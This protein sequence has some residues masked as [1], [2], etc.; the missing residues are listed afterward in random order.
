MKSITK[1]HRRAL[2]LKA[3]LYSSRFTREGREIRPFH[4]RV[5]SR[6]I[7][8]MEE[9]GKTVSPM[10]RQEMEDSARN[11]VLSTVL[12]M[13]GNPAKVPDFHWRI[14][15]LCIVRDC[16]AIAY[17][18]HRETDLESIPA[19][20]KAEPSE[21]GESPASR[22][23]SS[24]G[25]FPALLADY[26]VKLRAIRLYWQSNPS[27]KSK[28]GM[29]GDI[30][31]LRK[32]FQVSIGHG[33]SHHAGMAGEGSAMRKRKFDFL[34][35]LSEGLAM[36]ES[37]ANEE[38]LTVPIPLVMGESYVSRET[39]TKRNPELD[40]IVSRVKQDPRFRVNPW[41]KEREF[42]HA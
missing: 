30:A 18:R 15:A 42:I 41:T 20:H 7:D 3:V 14:L 17:A 29:R 1:Q 27:R 10:L 19:W 28:A 9:H 23:F 33:L 36:A 35:R 8:R 24:V 6:K 25:N 40:S 21:Q 11:L 26:K 16:D 2:H 39:F 4:A 12:A 13:G 34:S 37:M 5:V 22:V 32:A 31:F 38:T